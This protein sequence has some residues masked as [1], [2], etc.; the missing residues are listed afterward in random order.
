MK[1]G[2][3]L[4]LLFVTMVPVLTKA[5]DPTVATQEVRLNV[6]S[7][8]LIGIAGPP[9]VLQMN[10]AAE[11]GDAISEAVENQETRLR[12]SSLVSGA[13]SR[14]ISAKISETPVGTR[15]VVS[16]LE[17]NSNFA[18][19]M[20]MGELKGAKTLTEDDVNIVEG[21]GTCWSGKQDGDGYVIKYRYEAIEGAT[22]LRGG[23]VTITYT[24]FEA[25]PE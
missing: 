25:S 22:V 21:I 12:I 1:K 16:L 14:A 4:V 7:S 11:A 8:A 2:L 19:P 15:L 3:I 6:A 10:G 17:P 9:V 23:T 5:Q 24:I 18:N 13:E 20:Q